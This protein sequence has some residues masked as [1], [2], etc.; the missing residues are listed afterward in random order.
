MN[1]IRAPSRFLLLA[2]LAL[3]VLAGFAFDRMT[4]RS[5]ARRRQLVALSIGA[6]FLAEFYVAPFGVF[7][8]PLDIPAVDR[9]L[10]GRP[11]PFAIA[12]VPVADGLGQYPSNR[13]ESMFMLHA[14]AHRQK[15]VHGYSGLLPPESFELYR[16]LSRFPDETSLRSLASLGVTYVVVH[17]DWYSPEDWAVVDHRLEEFNSLLRLEHSDGLS[18]V[19][20]LVAKD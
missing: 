5:T 9:W 17:G 20:S 4:S 3:G 10:A 12:E 11:T 7:A 13:N 8:Q 6:L 15:T 1:F 14:M 18:R 19:Y 2:V 16:Q